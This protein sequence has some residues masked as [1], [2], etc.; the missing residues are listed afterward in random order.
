MLMTRLLP[1]VTPAHEG[2]TVMFRYVKPWLDEGSSTVS[3]RRWQ[4]RQWRLVGWLGALRLV[5]S[6]FK[7]YMNISKNSPPARVDLT[8]VLAV[9]LC[10]AV[11]C[12]TVTAGKPSWR[13]SGQKN[14]PPNRRREAADQTAGPPGPRCPSSA[15]PA[16][17]YRPQL[18]AA[19]TPC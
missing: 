1:P 8:Q 18:E 11:L 12:C 9:L 13:R 3:H 19:V 14:S 4:R 6:F 15:L 16:R 5:G 17:R 7:V 2:V 10:S